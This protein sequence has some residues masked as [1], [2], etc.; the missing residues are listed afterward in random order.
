LYKKFLTDPDWEDSKKPF[1]FKDWNPDAEVSPAGNYPVNNVSRVDAALFCNWLSAREK[2]QPCYQFTVS[3]KDNFAEV[4]YVANDVVVDFFADGYRLPT[5]A[6]FEMASR[7]GCQTSHWYGNSRTWMDELVST[8]AS[9]R[10]TA[11]FCGELMPNPNGLHEMEGNVWEWCHD[12][13]A[14]IGSEPLVD[15]TGPESPSPEF[16]S[17][18]THRGGGVNSQSGSAEVSARG[19]ADPSVRWSNL[20]FRVVRRD[21]DR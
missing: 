8:S 15:P 17:R 9:V 11:S 1:G 3:E 21:S 5:E 2:L 13:F 7:A 6:E 14:E 20:G 16:G 19:S 18:K 4:G 10:T 12:W